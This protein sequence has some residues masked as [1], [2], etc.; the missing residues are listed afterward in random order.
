LLKM[1]YAYYPGC[2]LKS[3]AVEYDMSIRSCFEHLG[4]ELIEVEDWYCCGSTPGHMT[5]EML[6]IALPADTFI[7]AEERGLDLVV[8]CAACFS[9]VKTACHMLG[10]D[11]ELKEKIE[12]VL[13]REYKGT[14]AVLHP[15]EVIVNEFGLDKLTEK[16][17]TSLSGMK[18]AVYYGC[19]LTR[20]PKV[21]KFD[22]PENPQ[23][24]DNLIRALGAEAVD[25]SHKTVCCG[26]SFAVNDP[27]NALRLSHDILIQAK[28]AGADS[29]V[30]AC[31][32]C[33]ANLDLNQQDIEKEYGEKLEMPVFYFSQLMGVALG[34]EPRALGLDKNVVEPWDQLSKFIEV[35]IEEYR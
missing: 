24:L 30:V 7:W 15:A 27:E 35:N 14:V 20:P 4:M 17:K 10:E 21:K 13:E 2:S 5:N 11:D 23:I 25:W 22:D 19:L 28:K 1:R 12:G 3:S 26:A 32:L 6:S 29:L 9:A 16:V 34:L 8:P 31:P 18:T 33:H